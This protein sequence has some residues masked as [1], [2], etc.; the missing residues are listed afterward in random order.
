[1]GGSAVAEHRAGEQ[2][3]SLDKPG[4]TFCRI[5]IRRFPALPAMP[6]LTADKDWDEYVAAAE[7]VSR[8]AGFQDLRDRI[9]EAAEIKADDEVL[10]LG[11]GTGLL[12]LP[13]AATASRVWA[14][15]ISQGMLSYLETKARSAKLDNIELVMA[16]VVSIP[17]VDGSI[18]VAIS[19]YC[20]H[21]L[22][23]EG[24][25]T[26]L[27]EVERI[28][29]PGGRLVLADMM[30]SLALGEPRNRAVVRDK[31]R[32][33][34]SKGPGGAWRLVRNGARYATRR[35]EH[36]ATPDWWRHALSEAGFT[37][38][39]VSSLPH[40]GGIATARKRP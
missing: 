34:L 8:S 11:A 24:K 22:P 21:H 15:D 18:D 26:A 27:A 4:P 32:G 25:M 19:N 5:S 1:M 14:V 33:L 3:A 20:F 30:F 6:V 2:V 36:P 37:N 29:K 38:V 16:S 10:D 13:S 40:E 39:D 12:T 23:A 28:L 35:W 17:L 7:A 9:L 31:V